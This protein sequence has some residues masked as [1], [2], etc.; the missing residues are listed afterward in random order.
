ME[1]HKRVTRDYYD[2]NALE[3]QDF[4]DSYLERLSIETGLFLKY[5]KGKIILD[6]GSGSGR[7]SSFLKSQGLTVFSM[8]ISKNM[9]RLCKE[10]GL[11]SL[12]MDIENLGFKEKSFDGIWAYTSLLH[13]PKN[14]I[15]NVLLDIHQLL[16]K[17]GIFFVGMKEGDFEGYHENPAYE[18]TRFSSLYLDNEFK[19]ILSDN[20]EVLFSSRT[21]PERNVY[22]NYLCKPI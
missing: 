13:V 19:T 7:D 6:L 22:L 20:F 8:D 11:T 15:K 14:K 21:V 9:T 18:S 17:D 1:K 10:K 5:I 16:K 4:V 2:K 12:V 3:Y